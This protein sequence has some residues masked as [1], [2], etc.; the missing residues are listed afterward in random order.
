MILII[1]VVTHMIDLLSLLLYLRHYA[2]HFGYI[3]PIF[4]GTYSG[5]SQPSREDNACMYIDETQ[6]S[7]W[8]EEKG[9][10]S[11]VA[12]LESH[13]HKEFSVVAMM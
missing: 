7:D 12:V 11:A 3:I 4:I 6:S 8:C 13:T 1:K 5:N 2:K 9:Q 10:G